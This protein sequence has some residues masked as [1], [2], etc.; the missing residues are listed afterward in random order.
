MPSIRPS[1]RRFENQMAQTQKMQAVGRFAG[2]IAH[3]FNN[4]LTVIMMA[5]DQLLLNHRSSDSSFPDI[6]Q[7]KQNANRAASLVRQLLAYSRKQTLRAEVLNLVDVMADLRML[8]V[9]LVGSEVKLG[10]DH[11]RDLWPVSADIGQ[12]EQV[13]I[14]LAANARDAM[15]DGGQIFVRTS[16]VTAVGNS[17]LRLPRTDARPTMC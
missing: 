3:D 15:P 16:N 2:G 6:M 12:L 10:I 1:R 13:I 11:G 7:I 9:R 4:V 17:G 14:N 8:L 5:S